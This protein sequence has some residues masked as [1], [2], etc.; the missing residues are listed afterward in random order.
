MQN[1]L[2]SH[3]SPYLFFSPTRHTEISN[4][5][6]TQDPMALALVEALKAEEDRESDRALHDLCLAWVAEDGNG[7][8][9]DDGESGT[10]HARFLLETP[11][12]LTIQEVPPTKRTYSG[13]QTHS[14]P[15]DK[16]IQASFRDRNHI[17]IL[18]ALVVQKPEDPVPELA[19]ADP[20]IALGNGSI[21]SQ[22]FKGAILESVR[23][24]EHRPNLQTSPG[25]IPVD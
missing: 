18:V 7:F 13:G 8:T 6:H 14:Y 25:G 16:Y 17:R 15:G 22:P 12:E 20:D 23:L 2:P 10:L 19:W 24:A 21:W 3:M 11:D 4:R 5:L 9:L 1:L